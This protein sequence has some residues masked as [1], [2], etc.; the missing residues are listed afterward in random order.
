[1]GQDSLFGPEDII[2]SYTRHEAIEDGVLVDVSQTAREAG[3]R[4]PTAVTR[5]VWDEVVTPSPKAKE[6]GQDEAGR[7]WDV[8]YLFSV[9]ARRTSG[10]ILRYKLHVL[11]EPPRHKV[12]ELKAV[13]GPGD[14]AEPVITI[15]FPEED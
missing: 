5:R 9:A 15:M 12:V 10:Q 7:L 14:E 4:Y 3:V 1:M 13:C 2:H 11:L 8:V 6:W